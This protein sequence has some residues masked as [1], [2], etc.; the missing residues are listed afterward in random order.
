MPITKNFLPSHTAEHMKQFQM[1]T[2]GGVSN[3]NLPARL[4]STEKRRL[5]YFLSAVVQ[6]AD[7]C[8]EGLRAEAEALPGRQSL[9][10]YC[11]NQRNKLFN[12]NWCR[13][14]GRWNVSIKW[15]KCRWQYFC[16][17]L[18]SEWRF[19]H[20]QRWR[21]DV[22]Q[23]RE[24]RLWRRNRRLLCNQRRQWRFKRR[25]RNKSVVWR[26]CRNRSGNNHKRV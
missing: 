23:R 15:R 20:K 8:I 7:I 1:A 16:I 22:L 9:K 17:W 19:D 5:M 25:E 14:Y 10:K 13:G 12:R 18:Y 21:Y 2:P 3:S 24:R 26:Y 4:F 11:C 6:A